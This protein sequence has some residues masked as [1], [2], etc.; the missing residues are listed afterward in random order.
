MW[1]FVRQT[2]VFLLKRL[3]I[4]RPMITINGL[5]FYIFAVIVTRIYYIC[6]RGV[7]DATFI[8][9]EVFMFMS[10]D[11]KAPTWPALCT[12]KDFTRCV[13]HTAS[14]LFLMMSFPLY[15]LNL[16]MAVLIIILRIKI[17]GVEKDS[18]L[19]KALS[20]LSDGWKRYKRGDIST[21]S[22]IE[23]ISAK[24]V[25]KVNDYWGGKR[26]NTLLKLIFMTVARHSALDT[27]NVACVC[28]L[29]YNQPEIQRLLAK[30]EA[31]HRLKL[32]SSVVR[33]QLPMKGILHESSYALVLGD[34]EFRYSKL[35]EDVIRDYP[36]A[37]KDRKIW[38]NIIGGNQIT[39]A[40]FNFVPGVLYIETQKKKSSQ[41][42]VF[43]LNTIDKDGISSPERFCF[44]EEDE[45]Q[46]LHSK[47]YRFFIRITDKEGVPSLTTPIRIPRGFHAKFYN[48]IDKF[49]NFCLN[50]DMYFQTPLDESIAC[51]DIVIKAVSMKSF[52]IL[53]NNNNK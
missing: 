39:R 53:E 25:P 33:K 27:L 10:I 51:M 16:V 17:F 47:H 43:V 9:A 32:L 2:T 3:A 13:T 34:T 30:A 7:N 12:S 20:W 22:S 6:T 8:Y 21:K 48:I 26:H 41:R 14:E 31:W 24:D 29:A 46:K 40:D 19:F 11:Q 52:D 28:H 38:W 1:D 36:E 37:L 5:I 42:E 49:S 18:L 44:T 23:V 4:E 45:C 15:L 35:Y 50:E